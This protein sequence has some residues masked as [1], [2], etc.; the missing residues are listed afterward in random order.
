MQ[1]YILILF[2][3]NLVNSILIQNENDLRSILANNENENEKEINLDSIINI[4]DSLVIKNPYKKLSFIG[5]SSEI[6]S[7]KFE[8]I[9]KELHF[10]DNVKE[11]ILK[12]LS[13]IGNIYFDNNIKVTISSVSLIG[14]IYSDF[15]NN[16]EYLKIKDFKYKSSTFPSNN[17]INLGGNVEIENSEFF[18]SISC[19][20]RLINYEGLDKYKMSIQ[21]SYFNGE[22]SC[23][24]INIKNGINITINESRFEKGFSNEEIEGG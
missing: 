24:F 2:I 4:D 16:N 19:K 7:L 17:C 15:K 1:F 10:T 23:P 21:N 6:S 14:N 11:V 12:D 5:K 18:G 8:D 3:T 9:S 13:I 20:N 22:N